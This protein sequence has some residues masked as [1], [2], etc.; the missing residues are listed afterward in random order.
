MIRKTSHY[1]FVNQ[2]VELP[3]DQGQ[4]IYIIRP[5]VK[6]IDFSGNFCGIITYYPQRHD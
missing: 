2:E 4:W 3:Q 6:L 1:F 5:V